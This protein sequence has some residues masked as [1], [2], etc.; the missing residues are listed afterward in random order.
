MKR[1]T[2]IAGGIF[3]AVLFAGCATSEQIARNLNVKN[4]NGSGLITDN[5]I[6]IDTETK[7]PVL[8]SVVI[9]GD[10]Q[11][12]RSDGNYI[13]FKQ[14]ESGAWYNAQN[15]TKKIQLT[16]TTRD[17]ADLAE[18]LKYAVGVIEKIPQD[19]ESS[20]DDNAQ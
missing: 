15:K 19:P 2:M 9:S 10:F 16:I 11:T 6:G 1:K 4:V 5:R 8:K 12:I 20:P 7:T 14:E 17:K 3:A 13:N 18:V